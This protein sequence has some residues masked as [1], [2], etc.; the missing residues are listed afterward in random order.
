LQ[1]DHG[2]HHPFCDA[3][4]ITA[5]P[6]G[7]VTDRWFFTLEM[8]Q[9]CDIS[10]NRS[11]SFFHNPSHRTQ[12]PLAL[13]I[14]GLAFRINFQVKV[15]TLVQFITGTWKVLKSKQPAITH[16]FSKKSP[17]HT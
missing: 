12:I 7:N 14:D 9:F 11:H 3:A 15:Q 2:L 16:P 4:I 1:N 13:G 6:H 10:K 5:N 17:C 8:S